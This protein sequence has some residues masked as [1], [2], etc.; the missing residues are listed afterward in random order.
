MAPSLNSIPTEIIDKILDDFYLFRRDRINVGLTCKRLSDV[1]RPHIYRGRLY[2]RSASNQ[3]YFLVKRLLRDPSLGH[4]FDTLSIN[5]YES[6]EIPLIKHDWTD[7]DRKQLS[8]KAKKYNFEQYMDFIIHGHARDAILIPLLCLLPNL[9]RL[10]MGDCAPTSLED[11]YRSDGDG[12]WLM[13][14]AAFEFYLNS[15]VSDKSKQHMTD[16]S[17]ILE[18][19]PPGL[20]SLTSYSRSD[21][22]SEGGWD[23]EHIVPFL[24]LPHM[25]YI[26]GQFL[27]GYLKNFRRF[28]DAGFKCENLRR[29]H[30][31]ELDSAH[32][33]LIRLIRAC[34]RIESFEMVFGGG[35][36]AWIRRS[37]RPNLEEIKRVLL[38][39]HGD[40]LKYGYIHDYVNEWRLGEN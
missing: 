21:S 1:A 13:E 2:I 7:D 31:G 27:G 8:A 12:S 28:L 30:F 29:L 23:S 14:Q 18:G 36:N 11:L 40:T 22:T 6:R 9:K 4:N 34:K 5:W 25:E 26:S 35:C 39:L 32:D 38:E 20:L 17:V 16:A 24:L 15:L 3:Q 33:D 19:F 10:D 37:E